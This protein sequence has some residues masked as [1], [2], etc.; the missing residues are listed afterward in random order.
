[1]CLFY[2]NVCL[3]LLEGKLCEADQERC[4]E[5]WGLG[6]KSH[7]H[8]GQG[9]PRNCLMPASQR[10]RG[11]NGPPGGHSQDSRLP[12][13]TIVGAATAASVMLVGPTHSGARKGRG[14]SPLAVESKEPGVVLQRHLNQSGSILN[15][16]GK[17]RPRPAGPHSLEVRHS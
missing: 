5:L 11:E 17:M 3:P 7:T 9:G 15:R 13:S 2:L 6:G 1:M 12:G 4:E 16:L 10:Y 14:R 8:Q